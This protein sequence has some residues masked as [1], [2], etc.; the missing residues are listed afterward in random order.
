MHL[1]IYLD[2]D[3]QLLTVLFTTL[4]NPVLLAAID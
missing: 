2:I 3:L 4:E 1:M